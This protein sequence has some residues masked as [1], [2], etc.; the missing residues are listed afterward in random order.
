MIETLAQWWP[1]TI[2]GA[3]VW[4]GYAISTAVR[5]AS[6]RQSGQFSDIKSVLVE[7]R[8]E[9]KW[10]NDSVKRVEQRL[11]PPPEDFG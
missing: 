3:I 8:S 6:N 11:P 7:I 5:I 10:T 2:G 9:V 1:L 4:A